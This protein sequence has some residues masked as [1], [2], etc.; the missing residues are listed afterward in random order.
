MMH[1][2]DSDTIINAIMHLTKSLLLSKDDVYVKKDNS[3]FDLKKKEISLVP[4]TTFIQLFD[5]V[6]EHDYIWKM[7]TKNNLG[8]VPCNAA[9]R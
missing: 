6:N 8:K 9:E 1:L 3:T 4:C 7:L 5:G 2:T